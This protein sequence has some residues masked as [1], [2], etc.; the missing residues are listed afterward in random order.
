ML[1]PKFKVVINQKP[2]GF[3]I[4][5]YILQIDDKFKKMSVAKPVEFVF[6]VVEDETKVKPT[7]EL[8][9]FF[10]DEFIKAWAEA[11]KEKGFKPEEDYIMQ[12]KLEATKYHLEDMRKIVFEDKKP[13]IKLDPNY[14]CGHGSCLSGKCNYKEKNEK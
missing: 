12:G 2:A 11:A 14:S 10:A 5:I 4:D 13:I 8:G 9:R 1:D 6:E 3:G 7:I